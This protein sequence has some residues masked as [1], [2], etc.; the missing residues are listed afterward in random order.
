LAYIINGDLD[1]DVLIHVRSYGASVVAA[2][3]PSAFHDSVVSRTSNNKLQ[4]SSL[5]SHY[6]FIGNF[7]S[8]LECQQD[9]ELVK[10]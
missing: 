5:C 9:I 6:G 2:I 8:F 7:A 4:D 1:S 3:L 10:S